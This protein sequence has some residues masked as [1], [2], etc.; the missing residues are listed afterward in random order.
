MK[1][2]WA[3]FEVSSGK[4]CSVWY[5]FSFE[6]FDMEV[7]LRKDYPSLHFRTKFRESDC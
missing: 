1:F 7:A 2:E 4:R 3:V 6:A 5:P